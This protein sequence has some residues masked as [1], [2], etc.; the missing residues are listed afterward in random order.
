MK[1]CFLVLA[2]VFGSLLSN[3]I[4]LFGYVSYWQNA[5]SQGSLLYGVSNT[6]TVGG[7]GLTIPKVLCTGS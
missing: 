2:S 7:V 3:P 6:G 4:I 5:L 1:R